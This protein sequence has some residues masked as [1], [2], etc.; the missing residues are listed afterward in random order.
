[1]TSKYLAQP[2][3]PPITAEH[4]VWQLEITHPEPDLPGVW[5]FTMT[6]LATGEFFN[7][8]AHR[9]KHYRHLIRDTVKDDGYESFLSMPRNSAKILYWLT[10]RHGQMILYYCGENPDAVTMVGATETTCG[11]AR[12]R[13]DENLKPHI[14]GSGN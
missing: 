9:A 10:K 4:R 13:N 8:P 6:Y 1:M 2:L 14:P 7:V 5:G 12:C 3:R 11:C